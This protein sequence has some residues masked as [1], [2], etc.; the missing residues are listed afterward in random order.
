MKSGQSG[1]SRVI[2]E[3]NSY[4]A[5][6]A[7]LRGHEKVREQME[8]RGSM[9]GGSFNTFIEFYYRP[10]TKADKKNNKVMILYYR[11]SLSCGK[12]RN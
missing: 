9:F 5:F 8:R 6:W 12:I 7:V 1:G 10:G 11:N 4:V 2:W 3:Q